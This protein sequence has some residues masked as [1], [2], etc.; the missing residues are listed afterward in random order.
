MSPIV[1]LLIVGVLFYLLTKGYKDNPYTINVEKKERFTKDIKDH[2][3]GL[4]VAMMAKVAKADGRV[5]ELEAELLS[6]TFTQLSSIFEN[7]SEIR[8]RLKSIYKAEI[9]T[10]ENTLEIAKKYYNLTK[11][12]YQKRLKTLEY[13]LNIAFIDNEFTDEEYMICEDIAATLE[14]K[15]SDFEAM[16]AKF[17]EFYANEYNKQVDTLENAYKVLGASKED[18]MATIKSKYKK[19]VRENHPD[20]LMGKGASKSIIEE[21]TK[22][23]Q[24]INEAYEIIKKSRS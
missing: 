15:K 4:L 22:K 11:N 2:E 1:I 6:N 10:F 7:S 5:S 14:I 21:A 18:D 23:L 19:L 8:E 20:L 17:R 13:L 9:T 12:D 16:V 3:V 24:E